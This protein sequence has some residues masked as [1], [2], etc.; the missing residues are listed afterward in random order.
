MV[1]RWRIE[2]DAR[3]PI[4][5]EGDTWKVG[6]APAQLDALQT[7]NHTVKQMRIMLVEGV[8][9]DPDAIFAGWSRPDTGD[10][11]VY[12]G[13]PDRDYRGMGIETPPPRGMMFLVFVLRDGTIDDWNWRK[14]Q[15]DNPDLPE[16]LEGNK[17]LWPQT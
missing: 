6:I 7:N 1:S 16:G 15:A 10:C 13:K 4:G 3:S 17:K 12:A 14:V 8:L 11:Y 5:S 9:S 2:F